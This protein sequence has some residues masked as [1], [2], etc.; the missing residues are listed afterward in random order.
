M[1]FTFEWECS[2]R[3]TRLKFLCERGKWRERDLRLTN[4]EHHWLPYRWWIHVLRVIGLNRN[5]LIALI[6]VCHYRIGSCVEFLLFKHC[7]C[8]PSITSTLPVML[9]SIF[10]FQFCTQH[11][12]FTEKCVT[13]LLPMISMN[14]WTRRWTGG[15][16]RGIRSQWYATKRYKIKRITVEISAVWSE[17]V[18]TDHKNGCFP[19]KFVVFSHRDRLNNLQTSASQLRLWL[20]L[21]FERDDVVVATLFFELPLYHHHRLLV[22]YARTE[23]RNEFS[24]IW[25]RY[26]SFFSFNMETIVRRWSRVMLFMLESSLLPLTNK[27]KSYSEQEEIKWRQC[28]C[29]ML[30]YLI[31]SSEHESLGI[32]IGADDEKDVKRCLFKGSLIFIVKFIRTCL[33]LLEQ[34]MKQKRTA[35]P[36]PFFIFHQA[37][38]YILLINIRLE[39]EDFFCLFFRIDDRYQSSISSTTMMCIRVAPCAFD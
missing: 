27:S 21:L 1:S 35:R 14:R 9:F 17:K 36:S 16:C 26:S 15:V 28:S 2:S 11:T 7:M 33:V 13:S 19:T 34:W 30:S 31:D 37:T 8:L 6:L 10:I 39:N 22:F 3:M 25:L 24:R 5:C 23:G 20:E 29:D 32:I 12:C 4:F 38:G 18:A